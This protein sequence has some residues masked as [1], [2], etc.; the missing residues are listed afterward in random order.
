MSTHQ[1]HPVS[2]FWKDFWH[3]ILTILIGENGVIELKDE[4]TAK[5]MISEMISCALWSKG[6]YIEFEE[7][8][9]AINSSLDKLL[10]AGASSVSVIQG[11]SLAD[12][13]DENKEIISIP[14]IDLNYIRSGVILVA[15]NDEGDIIDNV[16]IRFHNGLSQQAM[17]W[18]EGKTLLKVKLS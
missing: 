8:L 9:A 3:R 7:I 14:E 17:V 6:D 12:Y 16:L 11:V 15:T 2:D 1:T 4:D 5:K 18:F 13:L 10:D